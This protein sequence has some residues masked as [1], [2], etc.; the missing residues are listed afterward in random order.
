M[1]AGLYEP[2]AGTFSMDQLAITSANRDAYRQHISAVFSDF[3]L[4]GNLSGSHARFNVDAARGYLQLLGLTDAV[5]LADDGK[6]STTTALSTGQRKRL[7]LL[8]AYLDDRDIMIFDEWAADQDP[9]FRRIFYERL[10]PDLHSRGKTLIVITH[11]DR[12]FHC[13]QRLVKISDGRLTITRQSENRKA[14]R[15]APAIAI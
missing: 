12:Y 9:E 4:F 15:S 6:L 1:L 10:L 11:D 5:C 7:A 8:S 13:G 3:H 2:D 14:A